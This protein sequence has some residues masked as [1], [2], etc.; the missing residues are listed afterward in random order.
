MSARG[1]ATLEYLA[2]IALVAAILVLGGALAHAPAV[3]REVVAQMGRA[4]CVVRGGDC[5]ADREPCPTGWREDGRSWRAEV[6]VLRLGRGRMLVR[7][8]RSDGTVVVT[9]ARETKGGVELGEAMRLG[10]VDLEL[11]AALLA[12]AGAGHTWVLPDGGAADRLVTALAA[13]RRGARSVAAPTASFGE[14]APVGAEAAIAALM[15]GLGAEAGLTAQH[16]RGLRRDHA[17]GRTTVYLRRT[18]EAHGAARLVAGERG[19]SAE[20]RAGG[21]EELAVTMEADGRPVSLVLLRVQPGGRVPPEAAAAAGLLPARRVGR[22]VVLERRLDLG[23]PESRRVAAAYL[24]GRRGP[25]AAGADRALQEQFDA[26]AVVHVRVFDVDRHEG[27][28]GAGLRFGGLHLGGSIGT[29]RERG[30]LVGAV[31]RDGAGGWSRRDDCLAGV[32]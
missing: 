22:T 31:T 18:L 20:V 10:F 24:A 23:D 3:G 5:D 9:E 25:A 14:D 26:R 6:A 16:L 21:A 1:Q 13:G 27:G 11:R 8:T 2:V 30:R 12:S 15:G 17:T 29:V 7:E 32:A 4:L 28:G 19:R